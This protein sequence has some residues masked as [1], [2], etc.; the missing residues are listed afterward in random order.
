V[1]SRLTALM[2]DV[3]EA[4]AQVHLKHSIVTTHYSLGG[5]MCPPPSS[6]AFTLTLTYM[7]FD[8]QVAA[9]EMEYEGLECERATA[10][11]AVEEAFEQERGRRGD[12]RAMF[13]GALAEAG[14]ALCR[15]YLL[16]SLVVPPYHTTPHHTTPHQHTTTPPH[17]HITMPH[18]Q[19]VPNGKQPL[20]PYLAHGHQ[21]S[22]Q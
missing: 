2:H 14:E 7:E 16:L 10:L 13:D 15:C 9:T 19:S 1:Q 20:Y 18:R 17:H 5:E 12:W 11:R 21:H 6:L 3:E 22:H 8:P 4:R